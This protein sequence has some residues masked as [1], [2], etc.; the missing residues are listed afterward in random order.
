MGQKYSLTCWLCCFMYLCAHVE[1]LEMVGTHYESWV[2]QCNDWASLHSKF[3]GEELSSALLAGTV[4]AKEM[5]TVHVEDALSTYKG[6]VLRPDC[7]NRHFPGK[8]RHQLHKA[9]STR[10]DQTTKK[11]QKG[12]NFITKRA[13]LQTCRSYCKVWAS[14]VNLVWISTRSS[15]LEKCQ[16]MLK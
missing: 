5:R 1:A 7:F 6:T 9:H 12:W 13:R 15:S 10:P 11:D 8:G 14:P 4:K 16:N 2:P 3:R